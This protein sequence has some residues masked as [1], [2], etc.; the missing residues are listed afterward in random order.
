MRV[1]VSIACCIAPSRRS[2]LRPPRTGSL[3]YTTWNNDVPSILPRCLNRDETA[4]TRSEYLSAIRI[5]TIARREHDRHPPPSHPR[6]HAHTYKN[7]H[8]HLF[9]YL[10]AF[11]DVH[12]VQSILQRVET[13]GTTPLGRLVFLRRNLSSSA[14]FGTVSAYSPFRG[15]DRGSRRL[16]V[17]RTIRLY[18]VHRLRT[19]YNEA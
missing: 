14:Y 10:Q 18:T 19:M 4:G 15:F 7:R 8:T 12:R 5:F 17:T 1:S 11:P 16:V 13:V 9:T 6:I 3:V 2:N